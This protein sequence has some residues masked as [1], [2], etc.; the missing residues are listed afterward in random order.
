MLEGANMLA[1]TVLVVLP[2]LLEQLVMVLL[3][4]IK[5]VVAGVGGDNPIAFSGNSVIKSKDKWSIQKD[6]S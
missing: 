1:N 2:L 4:V 5:H 3:V 6:Q